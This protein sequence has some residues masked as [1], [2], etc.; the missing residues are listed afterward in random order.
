MESVLPLG[1]V[2]SLSAIREKVIE[3]WYA[4]QFSAKVLREFRSEYAEGAHKEEVVERFLRPL[5]ALLIEYA[6]TGNS[7]YKDVYQSE[8]RR[9]APHKEGNRALARYFAQVLPADESSLVSHFLGAESDRMTGWSREIH[10][11]LMLTEA[12]SAGKCRVLLIGDCIM[13]AIQSMLL[14]AGRSAEIDFEFRYYY[15]SASQG[16]D[17]DQDGIGAAIASGEIDCIA[18]SYLSYEGIPLYRS[19]MAGA[20]NMSRENTEATLLGIKQFMRAHLGQMRELTSVPILLHN[21]SGLPLTRWRR[22]LPLPPLSKTHRKLLER[23]RQ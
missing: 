19:L 2:N 6:R 16:A 8:R 23:Q 20:A 15:F 14:A 3:T 4:N 1:L 12:S 18:A 22:R 7:L 9:Y 21:A 10:R 11:P 5:Y 13:G 17:I